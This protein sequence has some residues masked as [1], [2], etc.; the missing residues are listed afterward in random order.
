[1]LVGWRVGPL[2]KRSM[3]PPGGAGL[4]L[5]KERDTQSKLQEQVFS[6]GC[7]TVAECRSRCSP[8]AGEPNER[9]V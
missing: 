7:G 2:D 3:A 5:S 9:E 4:T 6:G 1:M 8:A